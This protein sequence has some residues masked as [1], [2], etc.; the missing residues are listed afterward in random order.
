MTETG[1]S[2]LVLGA[3]S[4]VGRYLLP[5]LCEAG[6]P[7]VAFS[8]YLREGVPNG[9]RWVTGDLAKPETLAATGHTREVFS[10]SP[11]WLL[12]PVLDALTS[13]GVRRLIAF[14]STSVFTK[15]A[16]TSADERLVA[17]RLAEGEARTLE[18]AEANG[19]RCVILRPTLIYAEG[20]DANVSR[21]AGLIRRV[22]VIPL[23][24]GGAGLRQPV[25]AVDLAKGALAAMRSE[26]ARGVY[27]V[28][29]GET[30]TYRAMVERVFAGM[31]R[32][33]VILPIPAPL[34]KLALGVA[35]PL[36]PGTT[37]EMGSRIGED[38]VFDPKPA[39]RDFGWSPRAF[40]PDFSSVYSS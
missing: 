38:L 28:P 17:A 16:S 8:R 34:F 30:L 32:R 11:I 12:A 33:P 3:T 2:V 15:A 4:L 23:A 7:A 29:G 37:R 13:L 39:R 14:S 1:D 25:H 20:E 5:I 6:I 22:G 19:V 10:L 24:G 18:W 26:T 27:A 35:G 40:H 21:I 31:G 36:L 9:V